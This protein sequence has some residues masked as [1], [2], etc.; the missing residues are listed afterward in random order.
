MRMSQT[1]IW[2]NMTI[3]TIYSFLRPTS[4]ELFSSVLPNADNL[5][6]LTR[7]GFTLLQ[8]YILVCGL[9]TWL[10]MYHA[11]II[12]LFTSIDLLSKMSLSLTT[13]T[14]GKGLRQYFP[15]LSGHL[16]RYHRC[17]NIQTKHFEYIFSLTYGVHHVVAVITIV[18]CNYEA[19]SLEGVHALGLGFISCSWTFL[20]FMFLNLLVEVNHRSKLILISMTRSSVDF[21][22]RGLKRE[23]AGGQDIR[24]KLGPAFF[25]DRGILLTTAEIIVQNTINL[26]LAWVGLPGVG[27]IRGSHFK[28]RNRRELLHETTDVHVKL[29][30]LRLIAR[31]MKR[32]NSI[33]RF[34]FNQL[35]IPCKKN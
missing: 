9:E 35:W 24:V 26:I 2:I 18:F 25:Y 21:G 10:M 3:L 15:Q 32:C 16:L 17:F 12:F 34:Q 22:Q 19:V 4:P 5:G 13:A 8:A 27:K 31:K 30:A 14:R 6:Y 33:V 29:L 1:M 23:L 11:L 20:L 28:I 7:A